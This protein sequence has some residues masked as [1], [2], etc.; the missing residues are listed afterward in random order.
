LDY[1]SNGFNSARF[2]NKSARGIER[3]VALYQMAKVRGADKATTEAEFEKSSNECTFKPNIGE[4]Q[5]NNDLYYNS[6]I[7][8]QFISGASDLTHSIKGY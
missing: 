6:Q 5:K 2:T 7:E 1:E 8:S 4:S 3:C